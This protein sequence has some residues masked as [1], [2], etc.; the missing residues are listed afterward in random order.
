MWISSIFAAPIPHLDA[1]RKLLQGFLF[2]HLLLSLTFI[3]E[4]FKI[5]GVSKHA[6]GTCVLS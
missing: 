4:F 3:S 5:W 6:A 1:I 2:V